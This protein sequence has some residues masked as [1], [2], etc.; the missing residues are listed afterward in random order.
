MALVH[1]KH[2]P[3]RPHPWRGDRHRH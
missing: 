2:R 1:V 3:K